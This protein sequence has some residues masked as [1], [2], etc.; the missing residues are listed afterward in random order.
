MTDDGAQQIPKATGQ[1]AGQPA[2][3][4]SRAGQEVGPVGRRHALRDIV[5]TLKDE[6]LGHPGVLKLIIDDLER[7]DA[8]CEMLRSYVDRFHEADKNASIL[9]ERMRSVTA[10]EVAYGVG[11]GL[12]SAIIGIAP[13]FWEQKP[14]GQIVLLIGAVLVVGGVVVRVIKR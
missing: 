11:V 4:S 2:A 7:S 6:D 13:L 5:K 10:I 3:P 8:E 9:D 1:E 14:L 12:G